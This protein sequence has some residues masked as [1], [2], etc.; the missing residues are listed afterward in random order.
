ML[1]TAFDRVIAA[2]LNRSIESVGTKR[3]SLGILPKRRNKHLV[4]TAAHRA[5]LGKKPD[6]VVAA[7]IGCT[8]Q[9]V[10]RLRQRIGVVAY[11]PGRRRSA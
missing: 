9:H 2:R 11:R 10:I 6:H 4:V 3:R 1:G 8:R 5:M 7:A